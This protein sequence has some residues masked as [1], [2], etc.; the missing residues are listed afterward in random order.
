MYNIYKEKH[1]RIYLN[2]YSEKYQSIQQL[3]QPSNF[4]EQSMAKPQKT[5]K[6]QTNSNNN[7]KTN[8]QDK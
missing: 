7:D 2:I 1:N 4:N 8:K 6:K 5:Q 3:K